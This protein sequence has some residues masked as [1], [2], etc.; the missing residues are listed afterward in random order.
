MTLGGKDQGQETLAKIHRRAETPEERPPEEKAEGNPQNEED[1]IAIT[2]M[3]TAATTAAT[4]TI[5]MTTTEVTTMKSLIIK[6]D[7]NTTI[8]TTPRAMTS[9]TAN[10]IRGEANKPE[11]EE[12]KPR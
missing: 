4:T 1:T 11:V 3:T 8:M 7:T 9:E 5:T 12:K 2:T 10:G 6:K